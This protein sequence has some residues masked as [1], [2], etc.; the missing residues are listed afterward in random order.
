[1]S[2]DLEEEPLPSAAEPE[3]KVWT[4]GGFAPDHLCA[5]TDDVVAVHDGTNVTFVFLKTGK[6]RVMA[7]SGGGGCK[8]ISCLTGRDDLS[9]L[10]W[11][12]LGPGPA[13]HVFQYAAP[14]DVKTM[15]GNARSTIAIYFIGRGT[16]IFQRKAKSSLDCDDI[17]IKRRQKMYV[18]R[19]T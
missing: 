14:A 13:V 2:L 6:S 7:A 12:D 15:E 18:G 8:G 16:I 19:Y 5:V 3:C 4:D 17:V 1:M 9:L 10:A 11:S